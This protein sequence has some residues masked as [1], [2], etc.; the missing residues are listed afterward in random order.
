[1]SF[2]YK[3]VVILG[4]YRKKKYD[5]SFGG[6]VTAANN[7]VIAE[8]VKVTANLTLKKLNAILSAQ[9]N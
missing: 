4:Y 1:M 6:A 8:L 9:L 5:A 2:Q 7:L 3:T